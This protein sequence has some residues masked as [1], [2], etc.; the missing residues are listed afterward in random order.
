MDKQKAK[1]CKGGAEKRREKRLKFLEADAAKCF[2]ITNYSF[3]AITSPSSQP[4]EHEGTGSTES[5][6]L[7]PA[8]PVQMLVKAFQLKR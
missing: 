6:P 5:S 2:K 4:S 7:S 1:K 3:G 8:I